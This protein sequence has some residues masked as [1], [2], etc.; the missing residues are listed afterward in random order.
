MIHLLGIIYI[1]MRYTS[2]K[3]KTASHNNTD[4]CYQNLT[5]KRIVECVFYYMLLLYLY[6][7]LCITT[8]N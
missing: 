2:V 6:Y 8:T 1:I 3:I 5:K 7:V 4:D